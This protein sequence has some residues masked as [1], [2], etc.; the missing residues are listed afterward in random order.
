MIYITGDTHGYYDQ[1]MDR[2]APLHLT[3]EDTV[4][5]AGDFGFIWNRQ[6]NAEYTKRLLQED[7]TIAFVDGNHEDFDLLETF[8]TEE[9]N[10]GMVHRIGANIVHLMRGQQ[11]TIEG[12]T[13]FT[14]GGAYSIDK[15]LRI[16]GES[17]WR[18]ELPSDAEYRTAIE[19]LNRCGFRTD[20]VV[21]HTVPESVLYRMGISPD[22]HDAE[23]T[24][25]LEWVY[26]ELEFRA[27]FAG[28]FHENEVYADKVY[29]LH[30]EIVC[31]D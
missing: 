26:S 27:W 23:L 24:G 20:Y 25:F 11:F 14:M 31:I 13:F 17:W 22:E 19:T 21:T 7:F 3:A 18:Q 10:G 1:F 15:A 5:V 4:I 9:W 29:V 12:K 28:H 6:R 8:P 2:I 30:E 16:E